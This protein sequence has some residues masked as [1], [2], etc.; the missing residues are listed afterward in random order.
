MLFHPWQ[1]MARVFRSNENSDPLNSTNYLQRLVLAAET[2]KH[3]LANGSQEMNKEV[4]TIKT[5][6]R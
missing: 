5:T 6:P 4:G 1:T 2:M 3:C